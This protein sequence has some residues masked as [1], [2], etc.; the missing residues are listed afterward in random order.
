MMPESQPIIC[1]HGLKTSRIFFI[2]LMA[3][4]DF[5]TEMWHDDEYVVVCQK[6]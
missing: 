6:L 3:F 1:I 2:D 5:P 4:V